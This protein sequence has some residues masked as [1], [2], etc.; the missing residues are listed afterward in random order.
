MSF[1]N[2]IAVKSSETKIDFDSREKV[3][4]KEI[5]NS[6][7]GDES[8]KIYKSLGFKCSKLVTSMY[9]TSFSIGVWCLHKSIRDA[10]YS[11]Y[12]FV[13]LADEIVDSFHRFNKPKLLDDFERDYYEAMYDG[14]SLNPILDSF[15]H[16]VKKYKITD[17]LVQAFIKSMRTDLYKSDYSNKE[18]T[19][20]IYGSADVVGLMC[21]KVFVNGNQKKYESLKPY[22]MALGSAFQKVNFLR[23]INDDV[24]GL[25]RSYFPQLKEADLNDDNKSLIL[26]DIHQDYRK[27]LKGIRKLPL[28][29]R[30]GV[31]IA[32]TYYLSLTNKIAKTSASVLM[33]KRVR[34]SNFGKIALLVKA[35]IFF[36]LK[37][38]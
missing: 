25:E 2:E 15:Q 29:A 30:L 3:N 13:R 36:K 32:Y 8:Y 12:G 6:K 17:D 16:T 34:I 19:Q 22:A 35:F 5:D 33:N 24:N 7:V 38:Y 27:A 4:T 1:T 20:Y 37:I 18:F 14:I 21:L 10:I 28:S 26:E 23:D 31:Y 11:I 9:S